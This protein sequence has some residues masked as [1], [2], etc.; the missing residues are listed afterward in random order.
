MNKVRWLHISDIHFNLNNEECIIARDCLVGHLKSLSEGNIDK[1][2]FIVITGDSTYKNKGYSGVVEY[3][4]SF[5]ELLKE[6]CK[7]N[8]YLVQGNHDLNRNDLL[9]TNVIDIFY[10]NGIEKDVI[11]KRLY[12]KGERD[13][14]TFETLSSALS[15]D[16][17]NFYKDIT[18]GDYDQTKVCNVNTFS[19][20]NMPINIIQIDTCLFSYE[21]DNDEDRLGKLL[22]DTRGIESEIKKCKTLDSHFNIIIGHHAIDCFFDPCKDKFEKL[23]LRNKIDLYLCGHTHNPKNMRCRVNDTEVFQICTG[24]ITADG[25]SMNIS[26]GEM[27]FEDGKGFVIHYKWN[28]TAGKWILNNEMSPEL[29]EESQWG[30]FV[31]KF[32]DNP[33]VIKEKNPLTKEIKNRFHDLDY[34]NEIEELEKELVELHK[35]K[36]KDGVDCNLYEIN[37]CKES[38]ILFSQLFRKTLSN[39]TE[40]DFL[41]KEDFL[42]LKILICSYQIFKYCI[43]M[44]DSSIKGELGRIIYKFTQNN[45]LTDICIEIL[46]ACFNSDKLNRLPYNSTFINA[47]PKLLTVILK[48]IDALTF[49]KCCLCDVIVDNSKEYRKSVNELTIDFNE[50]SKT[51]KMFYELDADVA[52]AKQ[53]NNKSIF[54]HIIEEIQNIND[55]RMFFNSY[56][57]HICLITGIE[58]IIN[59]TNKAY[60]YNR[61][62]YTINSSISSI[63][64]DWT[65]EVNEDYYNLF[66]QTYPK[67]DENRIVNDLSKLKEEL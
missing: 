32:I 61:T 15:K 27:S 20:T 47:H 33:V 63:K 34:Y 29:N 7:D 18:H 44:N 55:E 17:I 65:S 21:K 16:Y 52:F 25:S 11:D 13:S 62:I 48:F 38:E 58:V 64:Y 46:N 4:N 42:V 45:K 24:A 12:P 59:L 10:S 37:R 60:G 57:G 8:F 30:F 23:L 39:G 3:L 19:D 35:D 53:N 66:I 2:D 26:V 22:L 28:E 43:K 1:F 36:V 51:I 56:C 6:E 54:R 50:T 49:K 67:F 31:R 14:R 5:K 40:K 9:R 41:F